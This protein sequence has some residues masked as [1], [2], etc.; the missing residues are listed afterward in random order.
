MR[1]DQAARVG[2]GGQAV[3]TLSRLGP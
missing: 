1:S 3:I 2:P